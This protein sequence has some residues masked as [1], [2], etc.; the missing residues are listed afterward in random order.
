MSMHVFVFSDTRLM[1]M[2]EW[3]RSINQEQFQVLLPSDVPIADIHGF[4]PVRLN[5]STTG[6]ECD[7]RDVSHVMSLYREVDFGRQWNYCLSFR[8]R[9]DLD[10][11]FAANIAAAAYA[12]ATNGIV[13]DPQD[14]LV[15]S[16]QEAVAAAKSMGDD[17]L[18]W[19]RSTSAR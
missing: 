12:A 17:V 5:E 13:F 9:G 7:Y 15:M 3:Q 11:W 6:F 1:S 16:S 8:S 18:R 4:L 2:L 10:E 19:M 14:S